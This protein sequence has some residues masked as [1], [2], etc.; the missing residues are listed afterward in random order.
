MKTKTSF[1]GET[2]MMKRAAKT[3]SESRR[4]EMIDH[5][6]EVHDANNVDI[7]WTKGSK[8]LHGYLGIWIDNECVGELME[9]GNCG[10]LYAALGEGNCTYD[11]TRCWECGEK[12][13]KE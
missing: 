8:Y 5:L 1:R 13:W 11:L 4:K 6:R 12:L 9:C 3:I 7:K 10:E 2:D